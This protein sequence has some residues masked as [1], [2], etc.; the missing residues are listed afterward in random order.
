LVFP[1]F[2][3]ATGLA[4]LGDVERY[5]RGIERRLDKLPERPDRDR[6][7]MHIVQD[8]ED[9]YHELLAKLPQWA[10]DSDR[11]RNVRWM[12]EELRISYFAQTL[13]TSGPVSDKRVHTA[14][15]E[16]TP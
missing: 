16:L 1:G 5:L 11:V 12:I 8:L 10:Q 3:T 2:V 13:G 15:A 4:R 7:W 9:A 14:I 6:T